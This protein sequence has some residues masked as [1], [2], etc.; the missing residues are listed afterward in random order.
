MN[1]PSENFGKQTRSNRWV[2]L[3]TA[4]NRWD[5]LFIDDHGKT[6]AF[7]QVRLLLILFVI[8]MMGLV[9]G[10][11]YLFFLN[12]NA[13]TRIDSLRQQLE[14]SQKEVQALRDE[15]QALMIQL[16]D[17]QA[18][19][20]K[21][22][23]GNKLKSVAY[24][25]QT[26]GKVESPK[27]PSIESKPRNKEEDQPAQSRTP[28]TATTMPAEAPV[29]DKKGAPGVFD[30][31]GYF[32]A[33]TDRVNA[34]FVIRNVVG[35]GSQ[36]SGYVFVIMKDSSN[37]EKT[38]AVMPKVNLVSGKPAQI[39]AGN[40]FKIRNFVAMHVTSDPISGPRSFRKAT[41]L[42][43]SSSG[44]LTF[45]KTYRVKIEVPGPVE[46]T[47]KAESDAAG[48][49]VPSTEPESSQPNE[50]LEQAPEKPPE[51]EPVTANPQEQEDI[52]PAITE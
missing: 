24:A 43:F 30:F 46:K 2:Q 15:A 7:H 31:L 6:V 9:G 23:A 47:P 13:D 32:D 22:S 17:A 50:I 51:E 49:P 3:Y 40:S 42:I 18:T 12:K 20:S 36:L 26:E 52:A 25:P 29:A 5:L 38:W 1:R 16:A 11:I 10:S 39:R 8:V 37:D 21:T 35:G 19:D 34:R 28:A 27:T 14:L 45:D 44:E 41:V 33:A 48:Q 4:L